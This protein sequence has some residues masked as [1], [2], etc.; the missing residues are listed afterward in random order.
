MTVNAEMI[1]ACSC[2]GRVGCPVHG[3]QPRERS[4]PCC[5]CGRA[6]WALDAVCWPCYHNRVASRALD[7]IAAALATRG[8]VTN[9]R[10]LDIVRMLVGAGRDV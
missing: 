3:P 9:E 6:T 7:A 2:G 1:G 5:R 10:L 4:V 8:D